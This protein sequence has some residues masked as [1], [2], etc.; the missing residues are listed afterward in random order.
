MVITPSFGLAPLN[1]L[2]AIKVEMNPAEIIKFDA[3]VMIQ[4]RGGRQLEL[5][6]SGESEEPLV[7]INIVEFFFLLK[8]CV[9]F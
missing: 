9:Q 3:R 7:D 1:A 6:L 4:V 8:F 5:R 2:T